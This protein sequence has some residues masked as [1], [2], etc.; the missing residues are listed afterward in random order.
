MESCHRTARTRCGERICVLCLSLG[1]AFIACG[2]MSFERIRSFGFI[3]RLGDSPVA[4]L[5]AGSDG[6]I[7]GTTIFGG[8]SDKGT[9]FKIAKD[10]TG[11]VTLHQFTGV[12]GDGSSPAAALIEGSDGALYGTTYSG[13]N[14][15][16]GTIFKVKQDGSGYS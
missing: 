13:G 16:A 10:G 2:Q 3:D 5:L 14:G 4:S 7:Y 8:V 1:F 11:Y 9:V 12:N 6:W 15:N